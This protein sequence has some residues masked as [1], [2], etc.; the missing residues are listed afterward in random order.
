MKLNRT[1]CI[2]GVGEGRFLGHIIDAT[3]IRVNPKKIPVVID[4][5]PPKNHKEIQSLNVK[6]A[7]LS[8][9]LSRA[10]EKQLPFFKVLVECNKTKVFEWIDEA[11]VTFPD[12]KIFL[13][14]LPTLT[15]SILGE[16]L[17]L[18]LA[19]SQEAIGSILLA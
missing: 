8:R 6:L 9:F 14:N 19:T 12:L 15:A 1:K 18:Y 16:T 10:S 17:T 3:G 11:H 7:D 4:M 5:K 2:F 13:T